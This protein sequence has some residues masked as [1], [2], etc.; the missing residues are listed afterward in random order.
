M[1]RFEKEQIRDRGLGTGC[2]FHFLYLSVLEYWIF[3]CYIYIMTITQTVVIPVKPTRLE[4]KV[5]SVEERLIKYLKGDRIC[6][7][8]ILT[9]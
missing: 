8:N 9:A 6:R 3:T 5:I 4:L 2:C 7:L 1:L